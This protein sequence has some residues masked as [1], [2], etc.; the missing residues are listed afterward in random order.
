MKHKDFISIEELSVEEINQILDLSARL[1]ANKARGVNLKGKTLGLV[2]QK[3][4][5]RTR[6]SFWV[7]MNQLKGHCIYLSP[8]EL[9]LGE[10]ECVKDVSRVL[11]RYL[12]VIA[13]R[14][15]SHKMLVELAKYSS[16]PVINALTDLLH[17][18]QALSDIL[19]I[20][21]IKKSF[22]G[23]KLAYV[24]DGNNVL[25]SLLYAAAKVGLDIS[26]GVPK[27]Y[28]PDEEILRKAK[29][30]AKKTRSKI[31]K[32]NDAK[33]AVEGADFVY[34]DVWTSMHQE[35]AAAKRKKAFKSFQIN[36]KLL[37]SAKRSC[38]VMHCLPAKR[39]L[40]ITDEIMDG[41]Q[42]IV[43]D[44]AEN[45]LYVEQAILYL[46]LKDDKK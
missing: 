5:N 8:Q 20:K 12:D 11:S 21:E 6:V 30:I 31:K 23:I 28:E 42:S 19:T 29:A 41:P 33:K 46:L 4:S 27:G 37:S 24:G 17:P 9:Q 26:Y 35:K 10:R 45:R 22:K 25:H 15:F 32:T 44:Q 36:T 2:F 38:L 34:T 13:A 43:Y 40:E 39:G 14:T 7:G 18:C 16:V 1:K 3:P